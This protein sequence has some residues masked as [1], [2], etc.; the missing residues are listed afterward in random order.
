MQIDDI[1]GTTKLHNGVE[2]PYL[3]MG[4]FKANDGK[5]VIEAIKHALNVGYRLIDTAAI[6]GNEQGVGTALKETNVKR[7]EIFVTSKL[8]NASQGYESTFAAFDKTMKDLHL[9]YLDLYL[10]HWPVE[11]RYKETWRAIEKLYNQKRIRAIGV[12]N[13]MQQHL[14]DLLTTAEIVPM[15]NQVEFHP[16][17]VQQSLIDFCAKHQ[18][19]YEAWSPLMKGKMNEIPLLQEIGKKY[20]KSPIQIVLRWNLQKNVVVIPKSVNKDH[21]ESNTKIFDFELSNDEVAQIDG[22]DK[23][24]RVGPDPYNFDF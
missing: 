14:E 1:K 21:I 24:Y 18:I 4:T 10:I 5:E 20:G 11:G 19:Q 13:F 2:M 8:W 9:E 3:G 23:N 12:S 17:L 22:L 15:V 6:Y 16:L 7:E